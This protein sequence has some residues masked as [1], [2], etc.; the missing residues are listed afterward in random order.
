L[1]SHFTP[2][3]AARSTDVSQGIFVRL[4]LLR[5]SL[6]SG[7]EVTPV[8]SDAEFLKRWADRLVRVYASAALGAAGFTSAAGAL[9]STPELVDNETVTE[10][11]QRVDAAYTALLA[12]REV[13][14][15]EPALVA[16]LAAREALALASHEAPSRK[17]LHRVLEA[18]HAII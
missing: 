10:A 17:H 18:F 15:T 11:R 5:F 9:A 8:R 12:A 3:C 4:A 14:Q 6:L 1:R 16:T 13:P 7:G 2:Q